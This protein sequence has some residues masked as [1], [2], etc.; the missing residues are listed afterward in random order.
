[1]RKNH[2]VPMHEIM[3]KSA[4]IK[5]INAAS[6]LLLGNTAFVKI[7]RDATKTPPRP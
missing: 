7:L 2:A 6:E 1:M 5:N 4:I 3:T